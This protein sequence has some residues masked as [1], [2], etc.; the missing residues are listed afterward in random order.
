MEC[1]WK[2]KRKRTK[3]ENGETKYPGEPRNGAGSTLCVEADQP[4]CVKDQARSGGWASIH[5]AEKWLSQA[6]RQRIL[7]SGRMGTQD[8]GDL[9]DRLFTGCD[10]QS[11]DE[12]TADQGENLPRIRHL[13]ER[14][15][16]IGSDLEVLIKDDDWRNRT[17][18]R[19][20][21]TAGYGRGCGNC[22][23]LCSEAD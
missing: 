21:F 13:A 18:S 11:K 2:R 16:T 4:E 15:F 14:R 9:M 23:E 1:S 20:F 8:Q 3:G 10:L 6:T 7:P 12:I 19:H 5:M 22:L 17:S